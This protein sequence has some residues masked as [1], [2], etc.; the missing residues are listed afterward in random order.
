MRR[1]LKKILLTSFI[2]STQVLAQQIPTVFPQENHFMFIIMGQSNAIGSAAWEDNKDIAS[3]PNVRV[4]DMGANLPDEVWSTD[5]AG[6]HKFWGRTVGFGNSFAVKISQ[7]F[8]DLK[9]DLMPCAVPAQSIDRF[10]KGSIKKLNFFNEDKSSFHTGDNNLYEYCMRRVRNAQTKGGG[11]VAAVL[12]HQ[13]ESDFG[14]S[15]WETK[16]IALIKNLRNEPNIEDNLPF[17]IGEL[18][19]KMGPSQTHNTMINH[20]AATQQNVSVVS[21][22][23]ISVQDDNIHFTAEGLRRMGLQYAEA[24]KKYHRSSFNGTLTYR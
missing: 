22:R 20:I 8:P 14:Q 2:A 6:L 10:K 3:L 4:Y 5:L 16:V 12:F 18:S 7:D 13:G 11:K 15:V 9:I 19:Y 21:S 23:D 17:I 24:W 1:A